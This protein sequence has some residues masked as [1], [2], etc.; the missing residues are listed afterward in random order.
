[1]RKLSVQQV[2]SLD[3][4][5][6]EEDTEFYRWWE[7]VPNDDE[8]EEYFVATL[9]RAGTHIMGRVTYQRLSRSS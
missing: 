5:I 1:M 6:L 9:R 7:A 2:A 8:L 4:Y 3:G